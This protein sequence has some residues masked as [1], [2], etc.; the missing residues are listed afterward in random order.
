[1]AKYCIVGEVKPDRL[2]EY[3]RLHRDIHKGPYR[4][5]LN[6][7]K[8]SGVKEEAVFIY[9]NLA[10]IF[11]ETEDLDR[12]Y[13]RQGRSEIAKKWNELMAPMFASSYEFNVAKKLPVLEKV[14]DLNEQLEGRLNP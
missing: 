5:L 4:E 8:N 14:F 12:C 9:K 13:E 10:I 7:I 6:V 2:E 3:K 1:M 11:Y